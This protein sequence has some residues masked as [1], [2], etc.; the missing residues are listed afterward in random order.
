MKKQ[1]TSSAALVIMAIIL[2]ASQL[3]QARTSARLVVHIPFDFVAGQQQLPAG[4]YTVRRVR[5]DAETALIIQSEDNRQAATL[6][7]HATGAPSKQA[8]LTF[9]QY[10]D[11]LFLAGVFVPGTSGGRLVS[12][13]KQERRLRRELRAKAETEGEA[14]IVTVLGSIQ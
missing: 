13:S 14:K 5:S 6:L 4:R 10:G 8:K 9:R 3:A 1:I 11:Q 2:G 7:T 12:E